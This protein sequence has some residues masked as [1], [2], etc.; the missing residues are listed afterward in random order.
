MLK[1]RGQGIQALS[2]PGD[3][4]MRVD[5]VGGS[6]RS[7]A[8]ARKSIDWERGMKVE[9]YPSGLS[10]ED[11]GRNLDQIRALRKRGILRVRCLLSKHICIG[12]RIKL[13]SEWEVFR[14]IWCT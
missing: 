7:R 11:C 3:K 5:R 2:A 6:F 10:S 9:K 8:W 12:V 1:S 14:F 13:L 4:H